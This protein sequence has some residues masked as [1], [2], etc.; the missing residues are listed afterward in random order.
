MYSILERVKTRFI[1]KKQG[2]RA[3][4]NDALVVYTG[5]LRERKVKL[6]Q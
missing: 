2:Y 1:K 3:A 6:P 4:Y 5:A